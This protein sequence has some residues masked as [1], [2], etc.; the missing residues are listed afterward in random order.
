MKNEKIQGAKHPDKNQSAMLVDDFVEK[1]AT[2]NGGEIFWLFEPD[3]K[4]Q[5]EWTKRVACALCFCKK[6]LLEN[7]ISLPEIPYRIYLSSSFTETKSLLYEK[8]NG[9]FI[10]QPNAASAPFGGALFAEQKAMPFMDIHEYVHILMDCLQVEAMKKSNNY[11][12][13]T[14]PMWYREGLSQYIQGKKEDANYFELARK[15]NYLPPFILESMNTPTEK[16]WLEFGIMDQRIATGN[17]PGLTACASAVQ[18]LIEKEGLGFKKIWDLMFFRGGINNFYKE[19][20]ELCQNNM[21]NVLN[22][23]LYYL[24]KPFISAD[25][26]TWEMP[27]AVARDFRRE[28]V[29]GNKPFKILEGII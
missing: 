1:T 7:G 11:N 22:N 6:F 16:F 3:P 9:K 14:L 4:V 2:F 19:I 25:Q 24:D 10:L 17:H 12:Y 13:I 21:F 28:F 5:E 27:V 23:Y 8:S 15:L 26:K 29:F 18:F 20:E